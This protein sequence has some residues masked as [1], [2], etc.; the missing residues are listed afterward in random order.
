M[1]ITTIPYK[2]SKRKLLEN[3]GSYCSEVSA[4]NVFDGFSGTGIVSAY[5][6]TQDYVVEANDI[7]VSSTMFG[8]VFL[9]GFNQNKVDEIIQKINNLDGYDGWLT[10]N[11]SGSKIRNI[12]G[13]NI[14]KERP[15]AFLSKNARKL[16]AARDYIDELNMDEAE[17]NA[18]IFSIIIAANSV[19]NIANDQ[20]SSLKSWTAK[21]KNDVVFKSPTNIQGPKGVQHNKDIFSI[22]HKY[23]VAY[24]DPP[25]CSGVLYPACY[26]LND[27]ICLWDKPSLDTD[28]A[29]PRPQRAIFNDKKPM[30]FFSKKTANDVFNKLIKNFSTSK[31]IVLSY[32]DAPRNSIS[33]NELKKICQSYGE[34]NVVSIKHK[35]CTQPSSLNK[36]SDELKEYFFI[37]D[38]G[39]L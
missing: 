27:S 34:L 26:H 5:L 31:R 11:Y 33:L 32:S 17:K 19:M 30:D 3:I 16:D 12:R 18:V 38:T 35:I 23:D 13:L 36:I 7:S 24:L 1:K 15:M 2:G 25:Y 14:D 39:N 21:S 6:R 4:K 8:N 37:I 10:Q 9:T 29:L 28:Y 22:N 20:K